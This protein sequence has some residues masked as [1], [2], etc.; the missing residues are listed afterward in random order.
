MIQLMLEPNLLAKKAMLLRT[1][2]IGQSHIRKSD[3]GQ[4]HIV[5]GHMRKSDMAFL[6]S[7]I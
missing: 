6:Y 2:H 7:I 4:G 1:N 3:I 5:K